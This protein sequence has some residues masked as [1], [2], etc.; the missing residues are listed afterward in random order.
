MR[1]PVVTPVIGAIAC[2][3][4]LAGCSVA[5]QS[6]PVSLA[7]PSGKTSSTARAATTPAAMPTP[8]EQPILRFTGTW[9][10]ATP[11]GDTAAFGDIT[12]VS[13][14]KITLLGASTDHADKAQLHVGVLAPGGTFME[15]KSGGFTLDPGETVHFKPGGNH[16]MIL[17]VTTPIEAGS[18]T[19]ISLKTTQGFIRHN[20][21]ARDYYGF[22]RLYIERNGQQK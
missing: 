8:T 19:V 7:T 5:A 10:A 21:Q 4:A 14:E 20:F 12:N 2:A 11:S 16:I 18:V 15:T 3:V 1:E 9:V 6:S 22:D 13:D 17:N